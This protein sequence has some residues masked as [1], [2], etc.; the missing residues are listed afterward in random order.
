MCTCEVVGA[1]ESEV[2]RTGAAGA[3][4]EVDGEAEVEVAEVLGW[5]DADDTQSIGN[6]R[7]LS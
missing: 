2:P 3:A 5:Q 7:F 6:Q 1:A 4:V